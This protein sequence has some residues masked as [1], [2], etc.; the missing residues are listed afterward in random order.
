[1]AKLTQS[2]R[3]EAV[4]RYARRYG[5][6]TTTVRNCTALLRAAVG[7]YQDRIIL[8]PSKQFN[9]ARLEQIETKYSTEQGATEDERRE[10]YEIV[11]NLI[12]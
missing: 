10:A 2:Q 8:E 12:N 4:R 7:E 5:F 3:T 11:Q 1:M 6:S 9:R